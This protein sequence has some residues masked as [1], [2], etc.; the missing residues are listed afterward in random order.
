[1]G[2]RGLKHAEWDVP[3]IEDH[4]APYGGAWIETSEQRSVYPHTLVAPY[5]GAWIETVTGRKSLRMFQVAPYGGAW[6]ET[7]STSY[8]RL[9]LSSLPMGERGLKLW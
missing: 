2:E 3:G 4:V 6:I 5:G 9:T 8:T 1:M 7:Y